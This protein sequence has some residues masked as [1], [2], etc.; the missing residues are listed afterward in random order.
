MPK[1]LGGASGMQVVHTGFIRLYKNQVCANQDVKIIAD[2]D[3]TIHVLLDR[4]DMLEKNL[5]CQPPGQQQPVYVN[6]APN[7]GL[8]PPPPPPPP[9]HVAMFSTSNPHVDNLGETF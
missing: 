6:P 9:Q 4:V 5:S 8:Y 7:F 2:L 3:Q 1:K